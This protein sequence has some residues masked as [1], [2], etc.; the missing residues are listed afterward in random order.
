MK[1]YA[2]TR[3]NLAHGYLEGSLVIFHRRKRKHIIT[4]VKYP[5]ELFKF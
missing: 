2:V 4:N 3:N 5:A 1:M